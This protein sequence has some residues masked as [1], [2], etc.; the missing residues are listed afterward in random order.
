MGIL[1]RFTE[2]MSSNINAILDKLED[3]DKMVDQYLR[4]AREDFAKV[5]KETGAIMAQEASA[6]RE[7]DAAQAKVDEYDAAARNAVLAKNDS[8][9]LKLLAKKAEAE[10]IR[11]GALTTY[12]AAHQNAVRMKQLYN[13]LAA[14]IKSLDA[15]RANVKAQVAV[16][17]AQKTVNKMTSSTSASKAAEGFAAMERKAQEALDKELAIAELDAMA[18]DDEGEQ[19][20]AKYRS[21]TS[22]GDDALAALKAELGVTE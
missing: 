13:K 1:S 7:L 6:K 19:L 14:D 10:S 18:A 3:P 21:S 15:R 20:L 2:I 11:D 12:E 22:A 5:R 4:Q 8:D 16:A 9:A 17:E